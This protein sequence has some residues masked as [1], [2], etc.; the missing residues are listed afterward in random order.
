MRRILRND[1]AGAGN[2]VNAESDA[3]SRRGP[4]FRV[5]R[6]LRRRKQ[7]NGSK[8]ME[9]SQSNLRRYS[10]FPPLEFPGKGYVW[11][12]SQANLVLS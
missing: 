9:V 12:V 1:K 7:V 3:G 2:L 11:I 6:L 10:E 5:R 4:C 8:S